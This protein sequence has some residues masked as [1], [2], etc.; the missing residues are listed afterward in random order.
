MNLTHRAGHL[1]RGQARAVAL[2][3][4]VA[5]AL[6]AASPA[7]R[8]QAAATEQVQV[9]SFQVQGNTL[10]EAAAVQAAL[11]PFTG[12]RSL[13]DLQRAAQAVQALYGQAGWAAV[14]VYVPPQPVADGVVTLNVVEGKVGQVQVQGNQRLSAQRVRAALPSLLA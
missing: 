4:A 8:A 2:A 1:Q 14:V 6:L 13:A 5:V 3:A 11:A 7:A 12:A 9:R 10:L